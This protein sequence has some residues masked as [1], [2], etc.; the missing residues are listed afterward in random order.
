MNKVQLSVDDL[1]TKVESVPALRKKVAFYY[2][3]DQLLDDNVILSFPA[4]SIVYEGMIPT[5]AKNKG[6]SNEAGFGVYLVSC[7]GA[8]K[9]N[10]AE[11]LVLLKALRDAIRDTKGPG[12]HDWNY[13]GEHPVNLPITADTGIAYRQG[14]MTQLNMP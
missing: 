1:K 8:P 13:A 11:T 4:V 3:I 9:H 2:S 7:K 5:D 12:G 14:W 6:L 10:S